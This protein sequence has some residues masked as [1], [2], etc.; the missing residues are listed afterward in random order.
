VQADWPGLKHANIIKTGE[1]TFCIIAE[2]TDTE[3]LA[4]ARSIHDRNSRFVSRH[5]RRPRPWPCHRSCMGPG[6]LVAEIADREWRNPVNGGM[7]IIAVFGPD[8]SRRG[9]LLLIV[10]PA[11]AHSGQRTVNA[12]P[13]LSAVATG[14]SPSTRIDAALALYEGGKRL[15]IRLVRH[16]IASRANHFD[17]VRRSTFSRSAVARITAANGSSFV[18]KSNP[19]AFSTVDTQRCGLNIRGHGYRSLVTSSL[20]YLAMG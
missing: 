12:R 8:S 17:R 20:T 1:R 16:R 9:L 19:W 15:S 13:P 14:K 4:K 7:G 5:A 2:W 3:S 18:G 6:S 11:Y 10:L